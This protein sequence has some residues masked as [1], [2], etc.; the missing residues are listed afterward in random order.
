MPL[1]AAEDTRITRRLLDRYEIPTRRVSYHARSGP[2]RRA[3]LLAAPPGRRGPR[4]RDRRRHARSSAT[5]A[6]SSSPRGRRRAGAVVPIPGASAVLAAV[7]A[8]GLAG[9]RWGFEGFLPRSGPRA[10]GAAR[11]DRRRRAGDGAVRGAD[12]A[13]GHAARP[14]RGLRRGSAGRG[15]P[16]A[17][18]APRADR[19]RHARASSRRAVGDGTIPARGEVVL[20][21]GARPSTLAAD[22]RPRTPRRRAVARRSARGRRQAPRDAARQ[23]AADDRAPAPALYAAS[24]TRRCRAR[25]R[26]ADADRAHGLDASARATLLVTAAIDPAVMQDATSGRASPIARAGVARAGPLRAGRPR[27]SRKAASHARR[28]ARTSVAARHGV[29][30]HGEHRA[31]PRTSPSLYDAAIACATIVSGASSRTRVR[32]P[33][34]R[35]HRR[36]SARSRVRERSCRNAV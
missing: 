32:E 13:R 19:P 27:S 9:P 28:P 14:R 21:V 8:S 22:R 18:E 3:E 20:V 35:P 12:P 24:A 23:V 4:A 7:A 5:P 10:A 1:I 2:A 6:T 29:L 34:A 15:L 26:S 36:S 11:A 17:H 30:R 16:R 31:R 33:A 25:R